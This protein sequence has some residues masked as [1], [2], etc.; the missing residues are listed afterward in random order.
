MQGDSTQVQR[1]AV[2]VA[3]LTEMISPFD[4]IDG[5]TLT[6]QSCSVSQ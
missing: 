6:L 4:L 1:D 2:L 3:W 5:V